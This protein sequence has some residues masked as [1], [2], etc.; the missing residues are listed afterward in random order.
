MSSCEKCAQ[1]PL[2]AEL[3]P[4]HGPGA[5]ATA[6]FVTKAFF[7]LSDRV[8]VVLDEDLTVSKA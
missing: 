3:G 5:M 1:S 2:K 8:D 6:T 7:C 4:G